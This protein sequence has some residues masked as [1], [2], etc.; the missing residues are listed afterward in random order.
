M[1]QTIYFR[2]GRAEAER[3][4]RAMVGTLVGKAT[5]FPEIAR[6]VFLSLGFAALSDIQDDF[7]RKAR[8]G[9][10][11]DGTKWPPLEPKTL[12]YS[13]RFGPG[14]KTALK[15]AAGLGRANSFAPGG[16]DGL[17]T[18]QQ[19]QRWRKIYGQCLA[20]FAASMP[21]GE[22]KAK[23]AQVA[24][25]TIKREGAKTKLEVFGTRQVEVLRDTGVLFNSLSMGELSEG[26]AGAINYT[27]PR[28]PGGD[29]QIMT[30]IENGVIVGT[31]VK[32]ARSHNEGD[33]KRKIPAR[34]FLPKPDRVPQV[35]LNRWL[36]TGMR[37]VANAIAYSL[38]VG[39]A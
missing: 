16:K 31:N 25:A 35:W 39:G 26:G 34:P 22:A 28:L 32:Y 27:P 18:K 8:G 30:T 17:L 36:D 37:A 21:M 6:G 9:I 24:W 1:S 23:A 5:E 38:Q 33:P 3:V 7:I 12:A 29:Q 11:E 4:V 13:R 19:L 20:R 2:G 10:G 14:E 15:K